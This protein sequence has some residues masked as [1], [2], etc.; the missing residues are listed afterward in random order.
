MGCGGRCTVRAMSSESQGS[1]YLVGDLLLG[2]G[3]RALTLLLLQLLGGRLVLLLQLLLL[4]AVSVH[5]QKEPCLCWMCLSTLV[6]CA[7][8][9]AGV[10]MVISLAPLPGKA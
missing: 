2:D 9:H 8:R 10:W 6:A 7:A 1:A 3:A 5:L 4:G